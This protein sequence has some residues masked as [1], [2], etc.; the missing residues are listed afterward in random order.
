MTEYNINDFFPYR[1]CFDNC[2]INERDRLH[3]KDILNNINEKIKRFENHN[4][5]KE[6]NELKKENK[7]LKEL[8]NKIFDEHINVSK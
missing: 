2:E 7:K 8:I 5:I 6:N 1:Y 3:T 4:Y